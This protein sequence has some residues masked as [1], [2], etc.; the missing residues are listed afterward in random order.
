MDNDGAVGRPTPRTQTLTPPP[1]TN[2][3]RKGTTALTLLSQESLDWLLAPVV[4][5]RDGVDPST[6]G[7]SDRQFQRSDLG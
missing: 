5:V 6:S 2:R 3:E 7:F 1:D 4:V